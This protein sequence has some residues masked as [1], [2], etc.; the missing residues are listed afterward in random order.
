MSQENV[1]IVRNA[2]AAYGR[3][4]IEGV[5][6]LC[7]E[8]IVIVQPP[9]LPGVPPEQRGHRGVV[10]SFSIWPEQWDDYRIELLRI[11]GAP[12]DK[13]FVTTRTRGRGKQSG[14]AVDMEFSFVFT[15]R[16]AK[17]SEWRL[18]VRE[19]QA[20]DA[21]G[22]SG[23]LLSEH[24]ASAT[25]SSRTRGSGSSLPRGLGTNPAWLLVRL[26]GVEP[27]RPVRATRPSTLRVYQFR[28]SRSRDAGF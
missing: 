10:E 26:R 27:P 8:D 17:I 25:S 2:F 11:A 22:L 6:R 12:G 16:E 5:L 3:G 24:D 1:E 19:D 21:A 9:D 28:H 20:L 18:F 23:E 15:V 4:D 13:V 14:V 7:E